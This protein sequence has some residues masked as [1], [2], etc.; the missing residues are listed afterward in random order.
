MNIVFL[1]NS[2]PPQRTPR[3]VQVSRLARHL[4]KSVHVVCDCRAGE[5]D[6]SI[7]SE[8]ESTMTT[9][10]CRPQILSLAEWLLI[11]LHGGRFL[12]PDPE[13]SWAWSAS[14]WILRNAEL[15]ESDVLAT[16]G[17]PMSDHLAGLRIKRRTDVN[18]IAHFSDPW[19]DN[20]FRKDGFLARRMNLYLERK[21]M[22]AA[23]RLVFTSQET[24]ELV[25][26]RYP[27][28]WRDKVRVLPH[29]FDPNLYPD[30]R[31]G[32]GSKIVFRYI[33][34]FYG[35]RTPEPL[36][37]GLRLVSERNPGVLEGVSFELVGSVPEDMLRSENYEKLPVGLVRAV[38]PVQYRKSLEL[39]C[40]SSTLL[41]MDAPAKI[42]V[43]LPSKLVDYVGSG[44][45]LFGIV[46]PGTSDRLIR[47]MGGASV[48]PEN[49]DLVAEALTDAIRGLRASGGGATKKPAARE[50][51]SAASV[52]AE[53]GTIIGELAAAN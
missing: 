29:A 14:R 6:A 49:P 4:G 50:R 47:E 38:S 39:M 45:P 33:G 13:V 35:H 24:V 21:V 17:V 44:R 41:V 26:R 30:E 40:E 2:F 18:W 15:G 48:R 12:V 34:N 43:F 16:F 20:P 27:A 51:Y 22:E 53:F 10:L 31:P 5:S 52:A 3:A 42:S 36:F 9:R 8:D 37:R 23:D 7:W 25:M 32:Q 19:C 46:P 1:S 28:A 11:K